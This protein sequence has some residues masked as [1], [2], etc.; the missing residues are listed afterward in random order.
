M[1]MVNRV[2][3]RVEVVEIVEVREIVVAQI[4][5]E[6]TEIG[7][8]QEANG[9]VTTILSLPKPTQPAPPPPSSLLLDCHGCVC[10]VQ[11]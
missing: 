10:V 5:V 6:I 2:I 7:A 9:V 1:L 8:A 11:F 3:N 4:V